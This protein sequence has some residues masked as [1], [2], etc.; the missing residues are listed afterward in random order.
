MSGRGV[1]SESVWGKS[2]L[3]TDKL[4]IGVQLAQICS[5]AQDHACL[6][7]MGQE[8]KSSYRLAIG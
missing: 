1:I 8:N 3:L 7:V 5:S 2:G 6:A 4:S